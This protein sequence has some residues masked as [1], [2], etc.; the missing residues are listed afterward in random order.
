MRNFWFKFW[1]FILAVLIFI[2]CWLFLFSQNHDYLVKFTPQSAEIYFNS[3]TQII[4]NLETAKKDYFF[5]WL[6][7]RSG[8]ASDTWKNI[9]TKS[10]KQISFFTINGQIFALTKENEDLTDYLNQSN[11]R[12]L[13]QDKHIYIPEL[14]IDQLNLEKTEWF[15]QIKPKFYFNSFYIYLKKL[16]L[17]NIPFTFDAE[18][19][20]PLLIQGK[21]KNNLVTLT[22]NDNI[23]TKNHKIVPILSVP[24]DYISIINGIEL[25]NLDQNAEFKPENIMFHILKNISGPFVLENQPGMN[26]LT[27]DS[28][29]NDLSELQK[30]ISQILAFIYPSKVTKTLPD[31]S[32]ATQFIADPNYWQFEQDEQSEQSEQIDT[33][34][35][36]RI[37]KQNQPFKL[38][39]DA[40]DNKLIIIFQNGIE[41]PT[42]S[43]QVEIGPLLK[44]C[45][46]FGNKSYIM[47]NPK[48][49]PS[50]NQLKQITVA[51]KS[52]NRTTICI[53]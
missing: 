38:K 27:I 21:N 43:E 28:Q 24:K 7:D 42:Q 3:Q 17:L 18:T 51:N 32:V 26:V 49:F 37:N 35:T 29:K 48:Q 14:N 34:Q 30:Q 10:S 39:I 16:S 36:F 53:D 9:L 4:N 45:S 1:T 2:G 47:I 22:V 41:E 52:F 6:T 5:N 19:N 20:Q 12:Y 46:K 31:W 50:L 8:L 44:K 23:I 33:T 15:N 40:N 11:V 13:Q 25:K